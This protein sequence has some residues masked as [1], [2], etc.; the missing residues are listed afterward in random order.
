MAKGYNESSIIGGPLDLTVTDQ[1]LARENILNKK[2]NRTTKEL[3]FLNSKIGWVKLSSSVN[4][5]DQL[6]FGSSSDLAKQNILLGGVIA[7]GGT[8]KTGVYKSSTNPAYEK[9]ST[10]GIR[11]MP[12]ITAFTVNSKNQ[13]GTLR[14]ATVEFSCWS[15]EQLTDLEKLFMRPGFS[16]LVEWGNTMYVN[17]KGEIVSNIDTI[18]KYFDGPIQKE[19]VVAKIKD[20]KESSGNNYDALIGLIKNFQWSYNDQGGYDCRCDIISFGEIIESIRLIVTPS[21]PTDLDDSFIGPV[22]EEQA[23]INYGYKPDKFLTSLHRFLYGILEPD[24]IQTSS[25][26]SDTTQLSMIVSEELKKVVPVLF[27]DVLEDLKKQDESTFS[28]IQSTV[29]QSTVENKWEK[30][31][32]RYIKLRDFLAVL[33]NSFMISDSKK[34]KLIK[35][36]TEEIKS[37]FFTFNNHQPLD[38]SICMVPNLGGQIVYSDNVKIKEACDVKLRNSILNINLEVDYLINKVNS[39]LNSY[40]IEGQVLI[41]LVKSILSDMQINL[42]NINDFDLHYE[43]DLFEYFVVD[44]KLTPNKNN[45]K[46]INLTGL[47]STVTNLSFT[48]KITPNLATMI[49]ISAQAGGGEDVGIEAEN[50]FRWN[51]GLQDRV[52]TKKQIGK[53]DDRDREI[54]KETRE[55]KFQRMFNDLYALINGTWNGRKVVKE[56][57]SYITQESIER[58]YDKKLIQGNKSSYDSVMR[59]LAAQFN[60]SKAGPAGLIPFELSFTMDGLGGLK[61]GQAFVVNKGILPKTYDDNIGFIVTGIDHKVENNRWTTDIKAQTIGLKSSDIK[62]KPILD[63]AKP[64]EQLPYDPNAVLPGP[65]RDF[66]IQDLELGSGEEITID[67]LLTR[68]NN[69]P[70]IQKA[71]RDFFEEIKGNSSFKGYRLLLNGTYRS[72]KRSE[73]LKKENPKNATPG[74]SAHNY[75]AGVDFNIVLP[76]NSVLPKK[77]KRG[78]WILT[79][80]PKIANKHGI[81][82][83]GDFATY[84]DN[85]HFYYKNYNYKALGTVLSDKLANLDTKSSKIFD[86]IT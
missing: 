66:V 29:N 38:P 45:L 32:F 7:E 24:F 33:N 64:D 19:K 81:G 46:P 77:A 26:F 67:Q 70:K 11:P 73:E 47:K 35:F 5:K 17:N 28:V 50:M 8:K 40:S 63:V 59:T 53:F 68:L 37:L 21:I 2:T 79:G 57:N 56:K 48:S 54:I 82:W 61:I 10:M 12:G 41:T 49:A 86:N 55:D 25:I 80:I 9:Y 31:D 16:I 20:K 27:K 58:V 85:V 15:V 69:D 84:R 6:G 18:S 65:L 36:N 72:I 39:I 74:M 78:N 30:R 23:I 14:Q 52:V 4:I 75:G 3:S 43:E 51:E 44:R 71:F 13:F 62:T 60:D 22:T 34:T 1:L 83:G 42:G 76:D